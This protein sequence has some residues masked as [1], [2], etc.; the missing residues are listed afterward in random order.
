MS[1]YEKINARVKEQ[2]FS[3]RRCAIVRIIIVLGW[4]LVA[5]GAF[6]G[7]KA[8]GFISLTF[9]AIL[10]AITVCVGAFKTGYICRDIKF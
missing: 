4:V 6:I 10:M 5:L 8:I 1:D 3:R 9:M 7:L 2:I